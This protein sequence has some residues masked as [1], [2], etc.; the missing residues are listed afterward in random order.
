[1]YGADDVVSEAAEVGS[2]SELGERRV[3]LLGLL[4]FGLV[5]NR[6]KIR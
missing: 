6:D 3:A 1:M 5:G 4:A 2:A